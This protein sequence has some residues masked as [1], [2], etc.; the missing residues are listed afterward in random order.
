MS[1]WEMKMLEDY[2]RE[3]GVT[4]PVEQLID[5]HRMLRQQNLRDQEERRKE[6]NET[7]QRAEQEATDRTWVKC[8]DLVLLALAAERERCAS[9]CLDIVDGQQY[10]EAIRALGDEK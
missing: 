9:V 6:L 5:S 3:L 10:A 4:I 1:V 8:E 2:A 7:Y